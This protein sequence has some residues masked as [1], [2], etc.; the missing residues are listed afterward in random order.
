MVAVKRIVVARD[1]YKQSG[2]PVTA[3]REIS[4]LKALHHNNVVELKEVAVDP[5]YVDSVSEPTERSV[6]LFSG[7]S[8]HCITPLYR[9]SLLCYLIIGEVYRADVA[10]L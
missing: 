6:C 7:V 2:F 9:L 8:P 4:I 1:V 10:L 5:T 3:V